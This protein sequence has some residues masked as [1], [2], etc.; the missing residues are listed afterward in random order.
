MS[1]YK[2]TLNG[3]EALALQQ[4]SSIFSDIELPEGIDRD[5]LI[6]S[7]FERANEFEVLYADPDYM[8]NITTLFFKKWYNTFE[9]W[10]EAAEAEYDPIEN[11]DRY[12]DYS[13]QAAGSGSGS[14]SSSETQTRAAFNSSTL[15]NYEGAS[16]S[17][18]NSSQFSN[19]D[20]HTSHIHGNIGVTTSVKMLEE[21]VSF[22]K[23]FNVYMAIADLYIGEYCLMVY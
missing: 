18:S 14:S 21:H 7:I 16:G 19:T 2:I 22:W 6:P 23:D 15:E 5:I 8:R 13:G 11:Y 12:E 10:Q 1:R 4:G 3:V 9:R 20:G 17:G